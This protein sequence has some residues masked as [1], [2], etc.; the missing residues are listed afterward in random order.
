MSTEFN[1]YECIRIIKC[2]NDKYVVGLLLSK[3]DEIVFSCSNV[4][5]DGK[6]LNVKSILDWFSLLIKLKKW[7]KKF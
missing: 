3:T 2:V 4:I 7:V 1:Y 6:L 5:Y